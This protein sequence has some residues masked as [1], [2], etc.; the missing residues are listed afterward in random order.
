M[1]ALFAINNADQFDGRPIPYIP[2]LLVV[3]ASDDHGARAMFSTTDSRGGFPKIYAPGEQVPMANGDVT[4]PGNSQL[5]EF[6]LADGSSI[7]KKTDLGLRKSS[8]F[9]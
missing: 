5:S 9:E 1:P 6:I 8:F 2:E 4:A 3:G 7:C